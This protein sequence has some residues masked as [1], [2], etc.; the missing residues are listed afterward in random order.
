MLMEQ[1]VQ[2]ANMLAAH[3]R[4]LQNRG[5]AGVDGMAVHDLWTWCQ[6]HWSRVREQLLD[7]TYRPQPVR[8][9]EIPKPTGGTRQLGI[10]TVLDRLIQQ[11]LL[12]VLTPIF[13]PTFSVWSFGFRPGRSCHDA[14]RAARTHMAAGHRWVVDMDLEKF[15]DRVNHDVLMSRVARQVQDHRVL[16]LIRRYLRAG[17]LEGGVVSPRREGT[18]Q[19]GPLSPLLSNIL[20]DG[21]DR[22]L[23][24]RGHRFVRYADDCNIYV[25]S[26]RAGERVLDSLER[27]LRCRLRLR[28]NRDKSAVDHPWRRSFLGYS[29]TTHYEPRL[30]VSPQSVKRLKQKLKPLLRAGRGR[31]LRHVCATL[32]PL[33]RGWTA[34]YRLAEVKIAFER[35]DQ[36]L[37]RKL[38]ALLWRVWRRPW[39]RAKQLIARGIEHARAWVSATNGRGAWWNAKAS[40]MNQAIPT[41]ALRDLGLLSLLDEHRR[42]ACLH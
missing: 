40:H 34:Y 26:R 27:F 24:Q 35:L 36:W 5:A 8:R 16:T 22:E 7:G 31:Q 1:V 41:R 23:E 9:V 33:L 29:V 39:T 32:A 14:V 42:L 28:V 4:V 37:R 10:P 20:L 11:A 19:G 6:Q 17:V 21:L 38:R 2:R 25:R 13:D 15:F 12:Q 18:P 30:K 3:R